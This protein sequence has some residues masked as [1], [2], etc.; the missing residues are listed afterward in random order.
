MQGNE[1]AGLLYAICGFASLS[2]GDA[3][4]KSIA[5]DWPVTAV[6]ALRFSIGAVALSALLLIKEGP[7]A[8]RP[9]SPWLQAGRGICLAFASLSFFAAIYVMPLAETMAIT[10]ISPVLTALLSGPLLR[11]KVRQQVWLASVTALIGVI[12][13]L[14]PNLVELGWP[15]ILPLVSATF[16]S[17]MIILNR[18][19]AGSGSALSM[20][21]LMA[22]VAAPILIVAAL[23][24]QVSEVPELAFGWPEWD[25]ILRCGIVAVTATTAHWLV[26]IGTTKAGAAHV[27][28][29]SYVQIIVASL[30]GWMLFSE[31]PDLLT[32][33]G[34]AI[35]IGSGLYLW[36][37]GGEVKPA[38][39]G[40]PETKANGV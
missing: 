37:S 1:R 13:I 26:Y 4:V 9:R 33:A 35:I 40:K 3:V 21:A 17:L 27:A 16:F 30:L 6:A 38:S 8:F 39:P 32:F 24:G 18:A 15:A 29:A 36:R 10:F 20:Q 31:V 14:R 23:I 7:S 12:I 19:A 25:V 34:A 11:E 2:V 22:L 5:G 28:P